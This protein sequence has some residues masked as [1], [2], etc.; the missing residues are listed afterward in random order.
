MNQQDAERAKERAFNVAAAMPA[1]HREEL[2][3]RIGRLLDM[4]ASFDTA[5]KALRPLCKPLPE[6]QP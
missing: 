6:N 5:E 4:G 3:S 1:V 2:Q